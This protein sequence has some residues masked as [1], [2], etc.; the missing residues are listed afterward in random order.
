MVVSIVIAQLMI[1]IWGHNLNR[2]RNIYYLESNLEQQR[3]QCYYITYYFVL[4]QLMDFVYLRQFML[5]ANTTSA[6][7]IVNTINNNTQPNSIRFSQMPL[8]LDNVYVDYACRLLLPPPAYHSARLRRISRLILPI[9]YLYQAFDALFSSLLPSL[10][11]VFL[12]IMP[13]CRAEWLAVLNIIATIF[14]PIISLLQYTLVPQITVIVT[15]LATLSRRAIIVLQAV[16][17][18]VRYI[19]ASLYWFGAGLTQLLQPLLQLTDI[20]KSLFQS[21]LHPIHTLTNTFNKTVLAINAIITP[22]ITATLQSAAIMIELLTNAGRVLLTPFQA[23]Y[24]LLSQSIIPRISQSLTTMATAS[25]QA[26]QAATTTKQASTGFSSFSKSVGVRIVRVAVAMSNRFVMFFNKGKAQ[27]NERQHQAHLQ[28]ELKKTQLQQQ[29]YM[30]R[31]ELQAAL[32]AAGHGDKISHNKS[33]SP[34]T[35]TTSHE[36]ENRRRSLPAPS[37]PPNDLRDRRLKGRKHANL[38]FDI[39]GFQSNF[40]HML[41]PVSD[42]TDTDG[43]NSATAENEFTQLNEH[44]L[45]DSVMHAPQSPVSA[46]SASVSLPTTPTHK[47]QSP[48]SRHPLRRRT[49]A[50]EQS[51]I[52]SHSLSSDRIASPSPSRT[53]NSHHYSI[54][55]PLPSSRRNTHYAQYFNDHSVPHSPSYSPKLAHVSS[56]SSISAIENDSFI[57]PSG[58]VK[59]SPSSKSIPTVRVTPSSRSSSHQLTPVADNDHSNDIIHTTTTNNHSGSDSEWS[60]LVS[61]HSDSSD[62]SHTK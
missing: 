15:S 38:S 20:F 60:T 11:N 42:T 61:D 50:V 25:F 53:V 16:I 13:Y 56:H 18:P 22:I 23:I 37:V 54:P 59:K 48:P 33:I 8:F 2:V 5:S 41:S 3:A 62:N 51:H 36:L 31:V 4:E 35:N 47:Y 49:L 1:R 10:F 55:S 21:I 58:I 17:I 44:K 57:R 26:K 40:E 52:R 34:A 39:T 32:V 43:V 45:A 7:T 9:L 46:A 28:A 14:A 6:H 29:L 30:N 24:I 19:Q 12:S 27:Y